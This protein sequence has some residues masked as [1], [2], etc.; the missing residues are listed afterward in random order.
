MAGTFKVKHVERSRVWAFDEVAQASM[1]SP[2][3]HLLVTGDPFN[4]GGQLVTFSILMSD[5]DG[6]LEEWEGAEGG[7]LLA[8]AVTDFCATMSATDPTWAALGLGMTADQ[9]VAYVADEVPYL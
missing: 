6:L 2:G 3:P 1:E 4:N 9:R 7:A 8:A 5:Y